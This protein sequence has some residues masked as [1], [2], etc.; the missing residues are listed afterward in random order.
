MHVLWIWLT[1]WRRND[2]T[3]VVP[4]SLPHYSC[5]TILLQMSWL[6]ST[7]HTAKSQQGSSSILLL[8]SAPTPNALCNQPKAGSPMEMGLFKE[9][10]AGQRGRAMTLL[11]G[12][13]GKKTLR[14]DGWWQR[15]SF[16]KEAAVPKT[17]PALGYR[18]SV[19]EPVVLTLAMGGR[20]PLG[21]TSEQDAQSEGSV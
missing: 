17:P 1:S 3:D 10:Q 11:T 8:H 2:D 15:S 19:S 9:T 6:P 7:R 20:H 21:S 16:R 4:P 5:Y 12:K 18:C 14:I 13:G